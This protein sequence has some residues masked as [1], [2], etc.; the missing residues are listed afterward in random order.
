MARNE[1]GETVILGRGGSDTSASYF[2]ALLHAEKVEI[3]TDVRGH[4]QRES[5]PGPECAPAVA[6]GL[7]GSAGD[8]PRPAPRCCI[9]AASIRCAKRACRWRSGT[10]TIPIWQA[11]RSR[12]ASPTPRRASRRSASRSRHHADLRW[13]SIGMWQQVGFLADV[14]DFFPAPWPVDRPRRHL[15]NERDRFARSD[16]EPRQYRCAVGRCANRSG[17]GLRVKVIAPCAG[18]HA[19]SGAACARC[20]TDCRAAGRVWFAAH[21]PDLASSNNLKPDLRRRRGSCRRSRAAPACAADPRPRRCASKT[22]PCSVRAGAICTGKKA[23]A[24][25]SSGGLRAAAS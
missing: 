8:L 14:F 22:P 13:E 15:G 1:A 24:R 21:A 6:P 16:R 25:A 18:D 3:W 23:P 2:G 12:G 19:W 4:V 20:C 17:Q 5:A 10:P 11:P 9:R 7:R